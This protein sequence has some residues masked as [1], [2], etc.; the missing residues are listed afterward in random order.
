M[1]CWEKVLHAILFLSAPCSHTTPTQWCKPGTYETMHFTLSL[2]WDFYGI[3]AQQSPTVSG[4]N[5]SSSSTIMCLNCPNFTLQHDNDPITQT[6]AQNRSFGHHRVQI[7]TSLC[8]SGNTCRGKKEAWQ[9]K[10][11]MQLCNILHLSK[12]KGLQDQILISFIIFY[13]LNCTFQ[14]VSLLITHSWYYITCLTAILHNCLKVLH[15]AV[16]TPKL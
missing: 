15:S 12:S 2:W 7:L 16:Q 3:E 6:F 14:A 5:I 8:Q 13:L 11:L 1:L 10:Y 4:V 9:S